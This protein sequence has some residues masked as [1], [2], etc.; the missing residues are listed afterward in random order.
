MNKQLLEVPIE[1]TAVRFDG[2]GRCQP[3]RINYQGR[4]IRLEQS[5]SG[6]M[7]SFCDHGAYYWLTRSGKNWRIAS[8]GPNS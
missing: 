2:R 4:S 1:I 8:P 7:V 3:T 6:E 5:T